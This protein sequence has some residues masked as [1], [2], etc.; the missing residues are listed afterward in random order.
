[1]GNGNKKIVVGRLGAPHGV[2]GWLKLH[3]FTEN[4]EDLFNYGLLYFLKDGQWL[5]FPM[6]QWKPH[7]KFYAVKLKLCDDRNQ[8]ALYTNCDIA[9]DASQL[10]ETQGNDVYWHE[11]EGM[12]VVSANEN[13][14]LLGVIDSIMETGANDVL[15]IKP[16]DGSVDD[17]ER[18]VPYIDQVIVNIDKKASRITVAWDSTY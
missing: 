10:P 11:L 18:L 7:A 16:C 15:V 6:E 13:N 1:M 5:P 14:A 4:S 17:E 9:I 8:A 3:S 2:R 12:N